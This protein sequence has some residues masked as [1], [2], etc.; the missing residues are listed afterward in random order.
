MDTS[1]NLRPG[2]R[3]FVILSDRNA[4]G[5]AITAKRIDQPSGENMTHRVF[6]SCLL[7]L[8]LLTA[9]VKQGEIDNLNARV[10]QNEQQ[11]RHLSSQVGNV[12]QVLPG[13][14]EMWAQMQSMR[15]EL[16]M[17]RGKLDEVTSEDSPG[18]KTQTGRLAAQ[19]HRLEAAVRQMGAQLGISLEILDAP[20]E[21]T[22]PG[23]PFSPAEAGRNVD[24][25][26]NTAGG[27]AIST[28]GGSTTVPTEATAPSADTAQRLYDAG[29]N[30]FAGR[31]YRDA[32]KT[33]TEFTK[34]FPKHKLAS[35]AHF[36]RGESYYQ[37]KDY[38]GAA[39]AYNEVIEN[40]PGSGKLQSAMLKQGMAFYYAGKK[41]AA[42]LRLD[43]LIKK[44][45]KSPEAGRAKKFLEEI[46]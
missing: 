44:Y 17:L 42:K 3:G 31:N 25:V 1:R 29:Q 33:F 37:M 12:E 23:V 15:Q 20:L 27:N 9:C 7:A 14:A 19:I 4:P 10:T 11:M 34:V 2:N 16:N 35:N 6:L 43:Q 18:M 5:T 21:S 26:E 8:P 13:Q 24:G 45:P 22:E 40:F 39:L 30:A 38:A 46:K 32:V 28:A 41:D 36:W